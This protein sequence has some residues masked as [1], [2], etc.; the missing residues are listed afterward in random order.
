M[1]EDKWLTP[2]EAVQALNMTESK[3][4]PEYLLNLCESMGYPV[5]DGKIKESTI[6]FIKAKMKNM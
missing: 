1:S 5:K 6:N 2:E 4:R 3:V